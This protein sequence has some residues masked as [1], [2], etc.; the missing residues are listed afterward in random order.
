MPTTNKGYPY[1]AGSTSNNVPA[2]I[3][4]LATAIEAAPGVPALTQAQIDA[5]SGG[6]KTAGWLVYN[7]TT[8]RLQR[9]NGSAWVINVEEGVP[10][11]GLIATFAPNAQA[12][13]YTLTSADVTKIVEMSGGGTLTIPSG[14]TPV[15]GVWNLVQTGTSQVTIA[16]PGLTLNGT[17]GLKLRAQWSPVSLWQRATD[18]W[19]AM[20]DLVV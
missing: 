10:T 2:D 19:L 5:L 3:Q 14:L 4:A 12:G 18:S 8:G 20:G 6:A 7:T 11:G 13:N 17:P 1:P 16:A 15:G 9:W